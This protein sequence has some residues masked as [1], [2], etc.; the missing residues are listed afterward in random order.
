M[1]KRF[2]ILGC[3]ALAPFLAEAEIVSDLPQYRKARQQL[4]TRFIAGHGIKDARVIAAMRVVARHNFVPRA[5]ISRA[6]ADTALPIGQ[7]QTI[8]QPYV[9]ALMTESLKLEP[10]YRVLEIGTGSGY[11]AAVLATIVREVS[12]TVISAGRKPLPLMPS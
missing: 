4:V 9:V 12:A 3:L 10:E 7:G 11:Q 1:K 5:I 2:L 8:S 6:Y